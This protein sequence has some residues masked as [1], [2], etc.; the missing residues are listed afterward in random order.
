MRAVPVNWHVAGLTTTFRRSVTT[1]FASAPDELTFEA[2][3]GEAE[4]LREARRNGLAVGV[5]GA[6]RTAFAEH[7]THRRVPALLRLMNRKPENPAVE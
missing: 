3:A 6:R 1:D 5:H 4:A 2:G 7:P